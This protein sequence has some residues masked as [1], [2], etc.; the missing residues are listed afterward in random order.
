MNFPRGVEMPKLDLEAWAAFRWMKGVP[1]PRRFLVQGLLLES[2]PHLMVAEGGAG[3]TN[4][5]LDLGLKI[6]GRQPG[7]RLYWMS[8]EIVCEPGTVV[9]LTTEDD[10]DELH[11]RIHEMDPEGRRFRAGNRF[12]VIPTVN[13]GGAFAFARYDHRNGG[14]THTDEYRA[15]KESL[16]ALQEEYGD[17]RL[18]IIDTLNSTMHGEENAATT[19]NEYARQLQYIHGELKAAVIVTHHVR[20]P[21][22][23]QPVKSADDMLAAIRGSSALPAAFR[24]VLGMW[25]APDWGKVL[26]ILGREPEPKQLWNFGVLKAN[27]PEM[28]RGVLTLLRQPNG[29][30]DDVTAAAT[31]GVQFQHQTQCAWLVLAVRL[32]AEAG[33]PYTKG[34]KN[35]SGGLYARKAELPPALRDVSFR[36]LDQLIAELSQAGLLVA[37][38]ARGSKSRNLLDVPGGVFSA[39]ARGEQV[40]GGAMPQVEWE[41]WKW[42]AENG[43]TL[44]P[45]QTAS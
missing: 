11:I 4:L 35:D 22:A 38:S 15:F 39:S 14:V 17:L 40:C 16:L 37:C 34:S 44:D 23:D 26:P 9:M 21:D 25:C 33:Y 7:E 24:A 10:K 28:I 8:R 3:K 12:I 6:S 42:T 30:L 36:R 18:V 29:L 27:N 43:H 13:T 45:R 19:I 1:P 41:R 31:N 5:M 20:K 2:K 32:A